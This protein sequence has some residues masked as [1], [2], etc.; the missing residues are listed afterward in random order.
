MMKPTALIRSALPHMRRKGSGS[1][2]TAALALAA[3]LALNAFGAKAGPMAS[4]DIQVDLS[5]V[6]FQT[7][8]NLL[9]TQTGTLSLNGQYASAHPAVGR[10]IAMNA[11]ASAST[12]V[13]GASALATLSGNLIQASAQ[14]TNG[15]AEG[16]ADNGIVFTVTGSGQAR[17][18][19]PYTASEWVTPGLA[20]TP[21]A[22]TALYI[23]LAS[24]SFMDYTSEAVVDTT[25]TGSPM[26][27]SS[28]LTL[29]ESLTPG[30][31][32]LDI[33][34]EA[35]ASASPVPELPVPLMLSAGLLVPL[36]ARRMRKPSA[37]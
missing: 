4:A 13:S 25:A 22:D 36:L 23:T 21:Y 30:N 18:T 33:E 32:L 19:V 37:C 17:I 3:S 11:P 34:P 31:Y 28:S 15:Y 16:L 2:R 12:S 10:A 5:A 24:N 1:R 8:G 35:K 7:G 27:S 20:P 6:T 29:N 26:H 14:A 9:V